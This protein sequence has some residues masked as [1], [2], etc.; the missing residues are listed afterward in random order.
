MKCTQKSCDRSM[1]A[2]HLVS[3]IRTPHPLETRSQNLHL[4]FSVSSVS[5]SAFLSMMKYYLAPDSALHSAPQ[6]NMQ[7][8]SVLVPSL[9]TIN[10][11][12]VFTQDTLHFSSISKE[13][14]VLSIVEDSRNIYFL[15]HFYQFSQWMRCAMF[16]INTG[17]LTNQKRLIF[18]PKERYNSTSF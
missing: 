3:K 2:K 13:K 12:I 4:H 15:Q 16:Y 7:K 5:I 11:T 10:Q 18:S 17:I 9:R 8:L 14:N 6:S 1:S